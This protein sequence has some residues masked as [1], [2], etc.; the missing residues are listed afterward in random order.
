MNKFKVGDVV[1]V[2]R[3]KKLRENVRVTWES[4]EMDRYHNTVQTIETI[5][6]DG[7]ITF[8]AT[9]KIDPNIDYV[10][11]YYFLPSWLTPAGEMGEAIYGK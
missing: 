8:A 3:P 2:R 9:G 5:D 6:T 11:F 10:R 4:E 1:I 7:D